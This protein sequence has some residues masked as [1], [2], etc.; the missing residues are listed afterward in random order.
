MKYF[1]FYKKLRGNSNDEQKKLLNNTYQ[2]LNNMSI[3]KKNIEKN[4]LEEE[5]TKR[6]GNQEKVKFILNIYI[7]SN[8]N[9]ND[10]QLKPFKMSNSSA[11]DWKIK[12]KLIGFSGKNN[13]KLIEKC[14]KDFADKKFAIVVVIPIKSITNFKTLIEQN[15]KDILAPFN[16]LNEEQQPF[17]LFIDEEEKDFICT[18]KTISLNSNKDYFNFME[19]LNKYLLFYNSKDEDF[20]MKADFYYIYDDIKIN[21]LKEYI[22]KKKKNHHDFEIFVND[23]LFYKVIYG[24]ELFDINDKT[25]FDEKLKEEYFSVNK[26]KISLRLYNVTDEFFDYYETFKIK[27]VE[28]FSYIF[29]KELLNIILSNKQYKDLDKRNFNVIRERQSPKNTLLKYSGYYNQVGDI[30]FCNQSSF[31]PTKINI[32][33][34]GFMGS[35]KSTLINTLLGEKR[36]L[37]G[38]GGSMTNYISQYSFKEYPINLVDFPGFRA[39][40]KG[41]NNSSLFIKEIKSKISDFKKVNEVFHCFLFCIK[42]EDRIFDEN[43]EDTVKVFK[44]IKELKIRTYFL[45][46]NSE[47]EDSK[48]FKS[49]KKIIKNNLNKIFEDKEEEKVLKKKIFGDDLDKNI[50]PILTKDTEYHGVKVKGFGLDNLFKILYEYF[51]EKKINYDKKLF[52]DEQKLNKFIENNELLK[53]FESKNKLCRDFKGKLQKEIGEFLLKLFL[54]APKYIYTFSEDNLF[55]ILNQILD[56]F[57]FLLNYYLKQQ[58]NKE[59]LANLYY[60]PRKELIK[61][62]LNEERMKQM[63]EKAKEMS[64]DIKTKIPTYAKFLFPVLSPF[65]YLFGTPIVKFYSI[66][67]INFFLNKIFDESQIEDLIYKLYFESTINDLNE[68]IKAL[69]LIREK[70][71]Q[72]YIIRNVEEDLLLIIEDNNDNIDL[73]KF[74]KIFTESINNNINP[75]NIFIQYYNG[76]L[77][78][79]SSDEDKQRIEQKKKKIF[80]ASR[81]IINQIKFPENDIL[82]ELEKDEQKLVDYI[83]LKYNISNLIAERKEPELG[84]K[85]I[86][87]FHK[88]ILVYSNFEMKDP[89]YAFGDYHYYC[90][91]CRER[92]SK[93]VNNYHCKPCHFDLC[94]KCFKIS[95]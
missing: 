38:K 59:I 93:N 12:L 3:K 10:E 36:C 8:D 25:N 42:F 32:A 11:F 54:K 5:I 7:Y 17:F 75:L 19:K 79:Y 13:E 92:F 4:F 68:G 71:K 35:G 6:G 2:V 47:K 82:I 94:G 88:H 55:E 20:Q 46:T 1:L 90:D 22:L 23:K 57:S 14:E 43:D 77:Y 53:V 91:I 30:L 39:K 37:E 60:M 80:K 72:N 48:K 16:D 70:F 56:H 81:D 64:N 52:L 51:K 41:K 24:N 65:Y 74:T 45:I 95:Q 66:E 84:K 69:D 85:A 50:I 67:L 83:L 87:K 18:K 44:A 40:Q 73:D 21:K 78:F 76:K 89:E 34:G 62:F 28:F 49:F 86:T 27:E 33:I 63:A 9:I 58:S 61:S 26:L 31:C 29:Q 15:E